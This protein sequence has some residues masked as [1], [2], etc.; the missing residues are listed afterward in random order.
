[1]SHVSLKNTSGWVLLTRQCSKKL[2]VEISPPQ[3]WPWKFKWCYN[4][5]CCDDSW[6]CEQLKKRVTDKYFEKKNVRL[7][8]LITFCYRKCMLRLQCL[9]CIFERNSR[10]K[11]SQL[12]WLFESNLRSSGYFECST[13]LWLLLEPS[14]RGNLLTWVCWAL[15]TQIVTWRLK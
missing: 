8:T 1:M 6:S 13:E 2:L 4:C 3:S 10:G 12:E 7:W 14:C 9:T 11:T 15:Q 5:G